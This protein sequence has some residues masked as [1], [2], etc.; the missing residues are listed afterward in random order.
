MA[1]DNF[2]ER[3]AADPAHTAVVEPDGHEVT[4]G[5]LLANANQIVHG[6]RALG[7]QP[8]DGVAAVLPSSLQ[9]YE[10]FLAVQQ[11]GWYLTPINFHLVGPEI[12]YILR[13][14]EAKAFFA[15]A[16][17]AEACRAG[18]DEAGIPANARFS[19]GAIEGFR[20]YEVLKEG[21]PITAPAQRT[22]GSVMN[23]TSG[24][25]GRPKGVRRA[26]P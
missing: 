24:T 3:A 23:Y 13:D 21:Q 5:E 6:L 17:F 1:F 18:A 25:T 20:P 15:H 19:L 14:C 16:Q 12:A 4:A 10:I 9:A 26:L 8:G 2:W 11:A 22:L 7:L